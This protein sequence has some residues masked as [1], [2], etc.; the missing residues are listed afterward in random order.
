MNF[1]GFELRRLDFR[2]NGRA[3]SGQFAVELEQL[4]H[5][6]ACVGYVAE[7]CRQ[8]GLAGFKF[9]P[10]PFGSG[11]FPSLLAVLTSEVNYGDSSTSGEEVCQ[12]ELEHH[13]L[14]Y[15]LPLAAQ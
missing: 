10:E 14:S 15:R 11:T 9:D 5:E 12:D 2:S 6:F 4:R 13:N 8:V 1:G 3:V 7:R